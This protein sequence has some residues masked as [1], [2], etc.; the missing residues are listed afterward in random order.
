[1]KKLFHYIQNKWDD[2]YSYVDHFWWK[3]N[4]EILSSVFIIFI[5]LI[6]SKN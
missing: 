4:E 2:A 6:L 1:M 5:I 3:H